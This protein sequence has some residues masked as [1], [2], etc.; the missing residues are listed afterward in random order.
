MYAGQRSVF[1]VIGGWLS[2]NVTNQTSRRLV[3]IQL[4]LHYFQ[5]LGC[6]LP[7]DFDGV[8]GVFP[9]FGVVLRRLPCVPARLLCTLL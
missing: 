4:A 3:S 6:S 7:F 2:S 8:F 9:A 5:S 1:S